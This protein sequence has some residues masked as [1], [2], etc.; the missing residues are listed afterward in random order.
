MFFT[1]EQYWQNITLRGRNKGAPSFLSRFSFRPVQYTKKCFICRKVGCWSTNHTHQKCE[2][3]KKKFSDCY[4]KYKA[5][6]GYERTLQYWITDYKG[7]GDNN[8]H[9]AQYFRD[10][11]IHM[12]NDNILESESV[13]IKSEQFHTFFGQLKGWESIIV[14]NTLANN[15]FKYQII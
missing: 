13:Y 7:I 8:E 9:I 14:V 12:Q 1:D 4:P 2:E 3:L 11:S 5:R 15:D 10:L 6:P